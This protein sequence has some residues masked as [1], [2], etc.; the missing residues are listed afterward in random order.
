MWKVGSV[1]SGP[2]RRDVIAG[3]VAGLVGG[4]VF[5][6]SLEAQSMTST[7]PGLLGLKLSVTGVLLH[8]L[9]SIFLGAAFGAISRYESRGYAATISSGTLYGM[10]WW[11]AGP[12]T[13]GALL[14]GRG[15]TWSLEEAGVAFPSLI[16]HLLYGGITGLGFHILVAL[17]LRLS[18]EPELATPAEAAKK[19]VVILGGGFGGVSVAQRLERLFARVP[20]LEITLVSQ[21][22]YLLFT[23]MLA[24]VASSALEAQHISAPIRASCPNTR[25]HRAEVAAIDTSARVVWV[26]SGASKAPEAVP[27][28]HLVMAL[29]S[30]P[31]YFDLPGLED[32]SFSMK[33]LEDASRLRNHVIALLE[34]GDSEQDAGERR[35]Q[36]TF[37]VAGGGFAGIETI[38][39]LFDLVHGVLRYYPNIQRSELRFVLVHPRDRILPELSGELGDYAL[40]KLRAR[41]IEFLLNARV[42]GATADAVLLN[43]AS[44]LETYTL[45]WTAGNQPNPLLKTLPCERNRA[46]AVIV[47]STL[48][49]NGFTNVWAIGDCAQ[50]P[51]PDKEG[52]SYPPT[53]Q[54]ATR[55]GQVVAENIAATIRGKPLKQFRFRTLGVLVGLGHRTAAAEIRG[56]RFSGLLAWFMWRSVYLGKLPGIEKKVR[57]ALDW[58]IDLFFPRDIVLTSTSNASNLPRIMETDQE[59]GVFQEQPQPQR[60]GRNEHDE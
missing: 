22:N 23:P 55:E 13:L 3:G 30:V 12:I 38:A 17:Y 41:G 1:G 26:R 2:L 46:G 18:P 19:R 43:E 47:D 25:C 10:L 35:R 36:L 52:Q 21:S 56:W 60:V 32:R 48:Q 16:G 27:Y 34:H 59:R 4:L 37:V 49:V 39:E 50:I 28:D 24:E 6:W 15:P 40:R 29:G 14:D 11:I 7:V 57:V 20:S 42:A 45:V 9:G 54:H 33:T 51:D 44:A 5:W 53:A 8:L 31:N 58:A